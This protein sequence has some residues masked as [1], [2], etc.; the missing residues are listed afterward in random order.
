MGVLNYLYIASGLPSARYETAKKVSAASSN[1]VCRTGTIR[2]FKGDNRPQ[3]QQ[4]CRSLDADRLAKT[5]S[6]HRRKLS[7]VKSIPRKKDTTRL[8]PVYLYPTPHRE[9]VQIIAPWI[10]FDGSFGQHRPAPNAYSR[11][12]TKES[13]A[14][15]MLL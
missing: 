2:N 5:R 12:G 14:Q 8:D 7:N 10:I 1:S 13:L 4:R 9:A 11:R 15:E 6:I 3:M